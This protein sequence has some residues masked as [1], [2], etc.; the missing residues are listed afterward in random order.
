MNRTIFFFVITFLLFP[1]AT[2]CAMECEIVG[3]AGNAVYQ[4]NAREVIYFK[5]IF[6]LNKSKKLAWTLSITLPTIDERNFKTNLKI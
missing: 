4:A 6:L 3:E 1:G 2:F 5:S